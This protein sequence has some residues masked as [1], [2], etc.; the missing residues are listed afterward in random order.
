MSTAA[1]SRRDGVDKAEDVGGRRAREYL[2]AAAAAEFDYLA[3]GGNPAVLADD[4]GQFQRLA[5]T[6]TSITDSSPP[7]AVLGVIGSQPG[8]GGKHVERVAD[9]Q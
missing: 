3:S 9:Q 4:A 2:G 6:P 1:V 8:V 7:P 5:T